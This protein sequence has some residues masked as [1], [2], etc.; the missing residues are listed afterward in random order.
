MKILLQGG[1]TPSHLLNQSDDSQRQCVKLENNE[2]AIRSLI[3]GTVTWQAKN[4][5]D[6]CKNSINEMSKDRTYTTRT[7]LNAD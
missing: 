1:I 3:Q 6:L 2:I 5:K 4:L 7:V